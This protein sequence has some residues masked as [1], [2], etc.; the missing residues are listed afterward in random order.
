LV[1]ASFFW[2]SWSSLVIVVVE[3]KQRIASRESARLY[4]E[5]YHINAHD[6]RCLELRYLAQEITAARRYRV[7]EDQAHKDFDQDDAVAFDIVFEA[8]RDRTPKAKTH[9]DDE[10]FA[11]LSSHVSACR[12]NVDALAARATEDARAVDSLTIWDGWKRLSAAKSRRPISL[13]RL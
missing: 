12:Q 4:L 1:L 2:L 7:S 6:T 9:Q 10:V 3:V 13:I 5:S 8:Y 11:R